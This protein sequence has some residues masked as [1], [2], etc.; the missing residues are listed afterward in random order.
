[1]LQDN[2]SLHIAT[3]TA[4]SLHQLNFEVLNHPLYSPD[5]APSVTYSVHPKTL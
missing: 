1:M 4:E 2:D 5:L 3:H